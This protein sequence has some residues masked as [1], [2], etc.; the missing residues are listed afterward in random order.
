MIQLEPE[1]RLSAAEY[2]QWQRGNVFPECFYSPLY[3]YMQTL[4][5]PQWGPADSKIDKY[6]YLF[7]LL[8]QFIYNATIIRLDRDIPELIPVLS[9][10]SGVLIIANVVLT[11][12]R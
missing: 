6:F 12:L 3:E 10:D 9:S 2:L 8:V 4:T 7:I 1:K 5:N 11:C